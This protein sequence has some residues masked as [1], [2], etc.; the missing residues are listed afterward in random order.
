MGKYKCLHRASK[1]DCIICCPYNFCHHKRA[2]RKCTICVGS[3]ICEHKKERRRC[4]E[5]N[6]KGICEHNRI[7]SRCIECNGKEICH[8]NKRRECCTMCIG[9]QICQHHKRKYFCIECNGKGICEHNRIRKQCKDCNPILYLIHL[10]RTRLNQ[11]FNKS[12]LEKTKHTIYYLGCT[13]QEFYEYIT[14]KLTDEMKEQGFHLDHIKPISKFNLDDEEEI[15]KCC[16]YT[17]IQPLLAVDN[18]T[19]NNKWS[20]EDEECWIEKIINS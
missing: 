20:E 3:Q 9:S 5:C 12:I 4:I 8:H 1:Y 19:K 10:Q 16:H 14:S 15:K 2:K 13:E 17:N 6:G 11:I 7:R 18:L